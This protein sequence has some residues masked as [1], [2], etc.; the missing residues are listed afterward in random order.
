MSVI[1][2]KT[3][4]VADI[5]VRDVLI[6]SPEMQVIQAMRELLNRNISGAPVLSDGGELLGVLSRKDCLDA[7]LNAHYHHTWVGP[8]S[9][10]MTTKVQIM[11]PDLDLVSAANQFRYDRYRRYPVM[12]N[13]KL[14]GQISRSDVL[15]ALS[16][17]WAQ[18]A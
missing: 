4:R 1:A 10:Y 12:D 9:D 13:G 17:H 2:R 15:H 18:P 7:A 16:K 11:E 3:E 5:M 6:L 8:V 14:V